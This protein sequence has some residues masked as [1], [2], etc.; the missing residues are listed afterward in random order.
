[1]NPDVAIT[2]I[3]GGEVALVGIAGGIVTWRAARLLKDFENAEKL[4]RASRA[5][6][7]GSRSQT[8]GDQPITGGD[9]GMR[10][11]VRTASSGQGDSAG[12][13]AQLRS[14]AGSP[15]R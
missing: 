5:G 13:A 3:L 7:R 9:P 15:S 12:R 8:L 11:A 10:S 14:G 4:K 1:M 2:I 6:V